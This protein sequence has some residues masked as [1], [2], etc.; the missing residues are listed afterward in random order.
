[1]GDLSKWVDS[2]LQRV[3]HL[4]PACLKDSQSLLSRLQK[5]GLLPTTAMIVIADATA[6]YTNIATEHG[7]QTLKNWLILHQQDLPE[8]FPALLV[9]RALET[10]HAKQRVP[11][12]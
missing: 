10:G 8:D 4:C 5:L 6:M 11:I 1:M 2:Q 9:M 3:V 7:L 12:R